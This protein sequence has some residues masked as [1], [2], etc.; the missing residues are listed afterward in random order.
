MRI[1]LLTL[2]LAFC[3]L[4]FAELSPVEKQF[5]EMMQSGDLRQLKQAAKSAHS[6][7]TTNTE[8]LDVAA[9][10]LLVIYPNAIDNQIDTLAW[11]CNLLGQSRNSR[12]HQAL[13]AVAEDGY[14]KK[15]RKYA[16]KAAKQVGEGPEAPYVKG[17]VKLKGEYF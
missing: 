9:E 11:V 16:A 3:N 6:R 5:V 8:V 7:G 12:Y 17:T 15:L 13:S 1:V 2:L 4:S 14:H 10:A